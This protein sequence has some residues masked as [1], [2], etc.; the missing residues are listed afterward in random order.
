MESQTVKTTYGDVPLERLIHVYEVYRA[1]EQRKYV[2][3]M[4]FFQTDEGKALNRSR[5]KAYYERNKEKVNEK[6]KARYMAKKMEQGD[7]SIV[8]P[9]E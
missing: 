2:K 9:L 5:Y 3:R 4:E 1:S 8:V 6:N 7:T